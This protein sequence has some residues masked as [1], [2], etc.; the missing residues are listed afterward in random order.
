[1][2]I[3]ERILVDRAEDVAAGDMVA[4]PERGGI[5]VPLDLARERMG[6]DTA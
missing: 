2:I 4:D 3:D 5:E 1:M 6:I